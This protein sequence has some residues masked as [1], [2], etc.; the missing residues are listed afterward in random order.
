M[1]GLDSPKKCFKT[2]HAEA[3]AQTRSVIE[4]S[5]KRKLIRA[6]LTRLYHFE[7]NSFIL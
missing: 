4:G 5:Q 2:L 1:T 3:I 7:T 6:N